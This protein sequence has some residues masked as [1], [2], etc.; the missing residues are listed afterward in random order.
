M[1]S[2][3]ILGVNGQDGILLSHLLISQ[4]HHLI[5]IGVQPKLSQHVPDS[6]EYFSVDIKDS[7]K[8][9]ELIKASNI[10]VIYNLAGLS[11]VAQSFKEPQMTRE[12]NYMAVKNLLEMVYSQDLTSHIKFFQASS[13]EMFGATTDSSQN[14]KTQFNPKSPYAESKVE[15]HILCDSYRDQGFFVSCGILFNHESIFRPETFVTRKVT[16]TVARIKLGLQEYLT[17]GNLNATRDWG[18][19]RDYVDAINCVSEHTAADNFVIATGHS[20]SVHELVSLALEAVD[21]NHQFDNLVRFDENLLR[22]NDLLTTVGDA[23]KIEKEIGWVSK[24][25]FKALIS[26]MVEYDLAFHSASH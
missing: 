3:L 16:S 15:A 4:G 14:E 19:A 26:E 21:L 23:R 25:P 20:H 18:A 9:Y 6:V 2:R 11:S 5:G 17:I 22:T 1:K 8:L 13:S 7:E 12:V 24:T 10:E